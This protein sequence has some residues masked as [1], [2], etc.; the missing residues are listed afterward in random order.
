MIRL[1]GYE[2]RKSWQVKAILLGITAVLQAAYI[3]SLLTRDE[4]S[5]AVSAVLL[6]LV[7]AWG[8]MAVGV[9]SVVILH[10][11]MNT[12]QGYMLFMTPNS[13][14]KILG[15]K[16]AENGLSILVLGVFYM[17]LGFLDVA[18]LFRHYG[19]LDRLWSLME[20]IL[21]NYLPGFAIEQNVIVYL[22]LYILCSWL[23]TVVTAYFADVLA[24]SM[25]RGKAWGGLAAF[26]LYI[27]LNIAFSRIYNLVPARMDMQTRILILM[28]VSL[29]LTAVMY[30]AAALLMEKK[31]SV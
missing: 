12:R 7:A 19:E 30:W 1:I 17:A 24:S 16:V 3:I 25:L 6:A 31:L 27:L 8:V 14:Y 20:Q 23:T 15:V 21:K 22:V 18:L 9:A 28:P 5:I 4:G 29:A 10:R 2:F 26:L 13:S 11:D